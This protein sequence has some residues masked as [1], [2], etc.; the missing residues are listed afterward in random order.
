VEEQTQAGAPTEAAV[1]GAPGAA[2]SPEAAASGAA[3]PVD[4]A[5]VADQAGSLFGGAWLYIGLGVVLL[6]L[7]LALAF[8][9][10]K[11]RRADKQDAEAPPEPAASA[12]GNGEGVEVFLSPAGMR[13][14]F[15]R[16]LGIY[17]DFVAGS[18]NLY[19]VPWYLTVG[20]VGSG[21]STILGSLDRSRV[22]AETIDEQTGR[23]AGCTWWYYDNAVVLDI[24][25]ESIL[26]ADGTTVPDLAWQKLLSLL[27]RHRARRPADGI[28]LA[29]P[30]TDFFGPTRLPE[31][32]LARKARAIYGKLWQA[33][34]ILGLCLP[35]YVVL[36]K[37]D[38]VPGFS[39]FA[40]ALPEARRGDILGWSS[41]QATDA[42]YHPGRID[43]ALQTL[44]DGLRRAQ[45]EMFAERREVGSPDDVFLL[46]Q[47]LG[48]M[49]GPL[50][51]TL[52][53]IF[54]QTAYLESL[55]LRGI[56]LTG[57]LDGGILA[58]EAG[59]PPVEGRRL[60]FLRDLFARKIFRESGLVR[61]TPRWSLRHNRRQIA[62]RIGLG[63]AAAAAVAWLW[64]GA[65]TVGETAGSIA[66]VAQSLP[67]HLDAAR[68]GRYGQ[69]DGTPDAQRISDMIRD[70]TRINGAW[71]SGFLPAGL[72]SS[73]EQRST[74]M[75]SVGYYKVI[76]EAVRSSLHQKGA[77][78]T[79][80]SPP[81]GD[82]AV[83]PLQL[84][85]LAATVDGLTR[86]EGA[87]ALFNGLHGSTRLAG[88]DLLIQYS[89]GVD[90]PPA[91]LDRAETY[92]FTV[93]PNNAAL[94][95]VSLQAELRTFDTAVYRASARLRVLD[96]VD[97][98]FRSLA[99]DDV[100]KT[101]LA[102]IV[103]DLDRLG[104]GGRQPSGYHEALVRLSDNLNAVATHLTSRDASWIGMRDLSF[105]PEM[106]EVLARVGDSRLLG[107][108]VRDEIVARAR[109]AFA[110]QNVSGIAMSASTIGP[111]LERNEGGR[112]VRLSASADSLRAS[113]EQWMAM[114]F[115]TAAGTGEAAD[116]MAD[117]ETE[118]AMV[119]DLDTLDS[120][121]GL[122]EDYLLFEAQKVGEFPDSLRPALRS[123]SRRQVAE[124]IL[125][126]VARARVA[127][128]PGNS[129]A[130]R[131]VES[132]L[133]VQVRSFDSA[134]PTLLQLLQ[135]L[136]H[137]SVP[138]ERDRL[139][140]AITQPVASLLGQIDTLLQNDG[141]YV[142]QGGG[143]TWW[144]GEKLE[145]FRVF[146]QPDATAMADHLATI[147]RRLDVLAHD[148]AEPLVEVMY[149]PALSSGAVPPELGK[150]ADILVQL[151]RY[152]NARPT[153]ALTDLEQFITETLPQIDLSTCHEILGARP[154]VNAA[155][156]YFGQRQAALR[157][158]LEERCA[159][160]YDAR[161]VGSYDAIRGL[162][163]DTLAGRYPFAAPTE[164][165]EGRQ[166]S[167]QDVRTF[168]QIFDERGPGL[169]AFLRG[170]DRYG[171]GGDDARRFLES[172]AVVRAFLAPAI[173]PDAEA[174]RSRYSLEPVFRVNRR[175]EIGG[176]EIIE[177]SLVSGADSVTNYDVNGAITWQVGAP[178]AVRLRWAK[179]GLT[180]PKG[181]MFGQGKVSQADRV[182]TFAYDAP[183][184][185]IA[186]VQQHAARLSEIGGGEYVPPHMMAF[187]VE[188]ATGPESVAR[189]YAG[190]KIRGIKDGE[191][192]VP[193]ITE[194][195]LPG[196][197]T[198]APFMV[199]QSVPM[200]SPVDLPPVAW[201]AR[202]PEADQRPAYMA[203]PTTVAPR[204]A[205][206]AAV[207]PVVAAP[208][209]VAPTAA[210]LAPLP[211][212]ATTMTVAPG[213]AAG[214]RPLRTVPA[215]MASG[216]LTV[217]PMTGVDAAIA[218]PP[219]AAP[220]VPEPR[221]SVPVGAPGL[222]LEIKP[223]DDMRSGR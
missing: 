122:A 89:L 147:R 49:R 213:S 190:L 50:R 78:L 102:E 117:R 70:Y 208:Q 212:T 158:G 29:L 169:I 145:P 204:Y 94:D 120:A 156:G 133:R 21:K 114:P 69:A 51:Q 14:S 1:T 38:S 181:L 140:Q 215:P 15:K 63:A 200:A 163:Q 209:A 167:L 7:V 81:D 157:Q 19:L 210:V 171:V 183:W 35:V 9:L 197:P 32:A 79:S 107:P 73:L 18:G 22:P 8:W 84:A 4:G 184:G 216:I 173:G 159:A 88:L 99:S 113:L 74:T 164:A 121:V 45:M 207:P 34:K 48:E 189:V 108:E 76:M 105:G 123:V 75:L 205:V 139:H 174:G 87:V 82:A 36:T 118:K 98:Y 214:Q 112:G 24:G 166:A 66:P 160:L 135:T 182:A 180:V 203:A 53:T 106:Q 31:A 52:T 136:E 43:E 58:E 127:Y 37:C 3:A 80:G 28:I 65:N 20:E 100:L 115:M 201:G 219:V 130:R 72:F 61:P 116:R 152:E 56:Y 137:L 96:L 144:E 46:P 17:R 92:G 143:F 93:P 85:R 5:N 2:A 202:A 95:G 191:G 187:G 110:R 161:V 128:A 77:L 42:V 59:A 170:N 151:D 64:S 103:A 176:S 168:F 41:P 91:F 211:R 90:V 104:G 71:D 40:R 177:W 11:S 220:A 47:R 192:A 83:R 111:L 185:L 54:R 124:G 57:D 27:A 62:V 119:W 10:W 146:G 131:R 218:P 155:R 196:F 126:T 134:A 39:A 97:D 12:E 60:V 68:Q 188:T 165:N 132:D 148:L 179:D 154:S 26:R 101:S 44:D 193:E 33:Q 198:A 67:G 150:W 138:V 178:L 142:P 23:P 129:L 162:F 86:F 222:L 217:S 125:E 149:Q 13:K 195:T 221:V 16:G 199:P 141:L 25:G 186:L 175:N 30:A 153:S 55:F 223:A 172:V 109:D 194:L 6:I 206:P